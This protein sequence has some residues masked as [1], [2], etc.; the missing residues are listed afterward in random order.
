M[1]PHRRDEMRD[2]EGRGLLDG[3][4]ALGRAAHPD[5]IA[6]SYVFFASGCPA[7]TRARY[8]RPSEEKRCPA[9]PRE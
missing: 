2:D 7:I 1:D 6:P 9:D 5:E 3:L 8:W 4:R